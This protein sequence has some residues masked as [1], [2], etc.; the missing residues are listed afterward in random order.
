MGADLNGRDLATSVTVFGLF[1]WGVFAVLVVIV[2]LLAGVIVFF[3]TGSVGMDALF[4]LNEPKA[5]LT[6][7]HCGLPTRAG[8]RTCRNCGRDLR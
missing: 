5:D 3:L 2:L 8:A 4:R 7:W 1:S 6:C